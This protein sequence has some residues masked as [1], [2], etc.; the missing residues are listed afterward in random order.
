[1]VSL[2]LKRNAYKNDL[3][4]GHLNKKPGPQMIRDNKKPRQGE[5]VS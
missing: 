2:I 5:D 3:S 1:V 4:Y